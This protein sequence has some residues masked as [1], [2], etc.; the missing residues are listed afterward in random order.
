MKKENCDSTIREADINS[1]EEIEG[2]TLS[3]KER[4]KSKL[5]CMGFILKIFG[6]FSALFILLVFLPIIALRNGWGGPPPP[7]DEERIISDLIYYTDPGTRLEPW[8]NDIHHRGGWCWL[9]EKKENIKDIQIKYDE[10]DKNKANVRLILQTENG[11]EYEGFV[12]YFYDSYDGIWLYNHNDL[13]DES[14]FNIVRTGKY[15]NCI[16]TTKELL[17]WMKYDYSFDDTGMTRHIADTVNYNLLEFTNHCNERV[18]VGGIINGRRNFTI[19]VDANSK[20][21]FYDNWC[22]NEGNGVI[23]ISDYKIY[24]VEQY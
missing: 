7:L 1:C 21:T 11:G 13:H 2:K 14:K 9:L 12:N 17:D 24:F 22:S 15:Y 16:T 10:D 4:S 23:Y 3:K 19:E 20:S 18:I 5:S 8:E 6:L